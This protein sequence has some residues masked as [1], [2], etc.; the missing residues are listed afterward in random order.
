MWLFVALFNDDNYACKSVEK[1][2]GG[3]EGPEPFHAPPRA[4]NASLISAFI[5]GTSHTHTRERGYEEEDIRLSPKKIR[6][7]ERLLELPD[8]FPGYHVPRII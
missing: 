8:V 5:Y 2:G 3:S 1:L 7:T 6:E 4:Q